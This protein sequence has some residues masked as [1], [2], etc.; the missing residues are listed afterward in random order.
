MLDL[1][2]VKITPADGNEKQ[3]NVSSH[4]EAVLID[5]EKG[6]LYSKYSKTPIDIHI[7]N[8]DER[9]DKMLKLALLVNRM[10]SLE[11]RGQGKDPRPFEITKTGNIEFA[12][13]D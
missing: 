10:T 4:S 12:H 9:A 1:S 11:F 8:D 6:E 2:K 5:I 7:A 3:F 13:K